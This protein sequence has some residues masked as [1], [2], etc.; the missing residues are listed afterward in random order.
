MRHAGARLV[1][2]NLVEFVVIF[3]LWRL[4]LLMVDRQLSTPGRLTAFV[5]IVGG[6]KTAFFGL[7]NLRQ[8]REASTKDIAYHK[9][10]ILMI[11]NMAQIIISFGLD[12]HI[13]YLLDPSS[14][15]GVREDLAGAPLVFE[16]FYFSALNFM[17]FGFGDIT[18]Q[19]VLPKA[20]TLTEITLAFV[21]VIFLLSDFISLKESLRRVPGDRTVAG[22]EQD[23]KPSS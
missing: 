3:A 23:D 11:V 10:M 21:T 15:G 5:A 13:F 20:V 1:L 4:T 7:E 17:F 14:F 16:F 9:F 2:R 12:Y 22:L 6:F 18:P 8:L 19:T